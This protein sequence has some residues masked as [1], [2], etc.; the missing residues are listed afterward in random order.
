MY[1]Y[2]RENKGTR[3]EFAGDAPAILDYLAQRR[4][5]R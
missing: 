4:A 5:R 1:A 2:Q 3:I